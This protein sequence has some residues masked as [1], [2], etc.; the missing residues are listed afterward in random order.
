M[1]N[2]HAKDNFSNYDVLELRKKF[3]RHHEVFGD[4][5]LGPLTG[6]T[7]KTKMDENVNIVG[8]IIGELYGRVVVVTDYGYLGWLYPEDYKIINFANYSCKYFQ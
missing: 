5:P 2:I 8:T 6:V 4:I 3:S 7:I 1:S